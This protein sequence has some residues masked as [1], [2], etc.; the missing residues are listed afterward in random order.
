V[1]SQP[2]EREETAFIL[3]IHYMQAERAGGDAQERAAFAN[4]ARALAAEFLGIYPESMR[5]ATL[6]HLLDSLPAGR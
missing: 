2:G 4:K 6:A 1:E 3:A 5:A